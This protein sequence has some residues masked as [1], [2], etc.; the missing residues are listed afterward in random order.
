MDEM[1]DIDADGLE[2]AFAPQPVAVATEAIGGPAIWRFLRGL[3][4]GLLPLV[5]LVGIVLLT[6]ALA[7][8]ARLLVA[9]QGFLFERQVVVPVLGVGLLLGALV[10]TLEAV[11]AMRRVHHW[12]EV[13]DTAR[14][15]G[16]LWAL[17]LSGAL[18]L[19]PVL[20]AT[21]LPQHP[22]P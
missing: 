19:L 8:V 14:A 5:L 4:A 11:L 15:A 13:G 21:L 7:L 6:L 3:L 20:L 17:G 16:A 10:Y 12:Q 1:D 22:A 18:V 2:D 9:P